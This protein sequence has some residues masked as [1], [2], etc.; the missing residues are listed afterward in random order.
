[1]NI[2]VTQH[3]PT[4]DLGWWGEFFD[5]CGAQAHWI[6]TYA[7]EVVPHTVDSYSAV[8]SLGGPMNVDEED[9]YSWPY[10]ENLLIQD[11]L[12]T[13]TPFMGL[14]LG[15]QLLAKAA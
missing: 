1:M 14:C 9:E 5:D 11:C 13:G 3:A 6:R 7:G 12:R 2:L 8:V 15:A 10:D 4:E